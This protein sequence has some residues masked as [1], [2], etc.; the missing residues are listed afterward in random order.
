MTSITIG[1]DPTYYRH[2]SKAAHATALPRFNTG[3]RWYLIQ[4]HVS[5]LAQ[6]QKTS[7]TEIA[8]DDLEENI[9]LKCLNISPIG[10]HPIRSYVDV[11]SYV[12][13]F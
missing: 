5:Q 4:H 1:W 9:M 12:L 10:L 11:L 2:T 8:D 3:E 13:L 7:D 6:T